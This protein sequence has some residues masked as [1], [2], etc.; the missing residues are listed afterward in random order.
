MG[1]FNSHDNVGQFDLYAI[2][3]SIFLSLIAPLAVESLNSHTELS[4]GL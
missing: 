1:F 4:G 2:N 3:H